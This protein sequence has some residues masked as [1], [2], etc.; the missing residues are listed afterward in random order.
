MAARLGVIVQ[1]VY[2]ENDISA[3]AIAGSER[4][5]FDEFMHDWQR[6][7]FKVPLAYTTGR[8]TRD[9][10]VA[11]RV[12]AAAR[13]TGISPYYVASPWCDLNTAAGRRMYRSLAVNDTGEAEDIQERV[14]RK[15][16]EDAR[17]GKAAGGPRTYGYGL[18]IGYDPVKKKDIRDPYQVIDEEVA[19]LQEG[20]RRTLAGDSQFTIVRDWNARGITTSKAGQKVKHKGNVTIC[21]GRWDVG[22]LKRT[23]LNECYIIFDPTSHP[24]DCPCLQNPETGGTRIHHTERHR[25]KWPGLFTRAEHDSM[26]TVFNGRNVY[27][28]NVGQVK[29]RTYL[30]SGIVECGGTWRNTEKKGSYCGGQ[31]YGQGKVYDTKKGRVYQRRYA[32]KK[33]DRDG[34]RLGCST[35]F[36]IADAVEAYVTE[37]VLFRFDSPEVLRA[38]TPADNEERMAQLVQD[39]AEL[40][41]RREQL[42]AEYARKE[43]DKDDYRVMMKAI[44]NDIEAAE[45][46][47]KQLLSTKAK[48]L[49]VPTSGLREVWD[50]A[51]IEWRASVVTLVVERVIIHPGRPVRK[52]WPNKNGWWFD[53]DLVEIVWLH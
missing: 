2:V 53:P 14:Q 45:S 27:W 40:Q 4:Q 12:I 31:M 41:V 21:D 36:R 42:A 26:A 35:V 34:S 29:A 24:T 15:K 9:N 33:W 3:S 6:G 5:E 1:K 32:C 38:L 39:L 18:V 10:I 23:L 50:T 46:E 30:L 7:A 22:R 28:S 16:L 51:S 47:K 20:K 13:Q 43:H 49:A 25:A 17:E 48:S 52:M 37:Q 19:V 11:E 8:L 44:K